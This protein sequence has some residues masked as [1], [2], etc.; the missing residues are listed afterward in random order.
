[1]CL[2]VTVDGSLLCLMGL[3][4]DRVRP[5]GGALSM[6]STCFCKRTSIELGREGPRERRGLWMSERVGQSEGDG[7]RG[8]ERVTVRER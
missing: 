5:E 3:E 8:R 6:T 1:M 7:E 4:A 2:C